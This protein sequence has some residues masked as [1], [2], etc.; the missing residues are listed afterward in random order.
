[1]QTIEDTD[2]LPA[3]ERGHLSFRGGAGAG[4]V[5][6]LI[7]MSLMNTTCRQTLRKDADDW[8]IIWEALKYKYYVHR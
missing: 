2:G 8:E 3:I 1:M 7:S 6:V 5:A 4:K